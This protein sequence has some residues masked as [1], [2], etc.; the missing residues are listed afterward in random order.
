MLR[1]THFDQTPL[2]PQRVT[3]EVFGH[4][5]CYVTTMGLSQIA[6]AQFLQ[7]TSRATGSIAGRPGRSAGRC[8]PRSASAPP[9][10]TAPSSR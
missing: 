9:I 3:N 8:L 4:D 7:S 1:K 6:G 5:T 2:K 10:R